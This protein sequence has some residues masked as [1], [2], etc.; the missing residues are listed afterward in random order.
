M[1]LF[2]FLGN[3][4]SNAEIKK[5]SLA[6][7]NDIIDNIYIREL[8]LYI[9][10]SYISNTLSN[11]EIKVYKNNEEIKNELYYKLNYSPNNNQNSNQFMTKIIKNL[12]TKGDCIVIPYNNN[13]FACDGYSKE[14]N[15][16]RDDIFSN[17]SIGNHF[18]NKKM[19]A[20]DVLY[21]KMGDVNA[22]L[23]IDG[24][25]D[26]YNRLIAYSIQDY[27]NNTRIKYK[28][29]L[30]NYGG[31]DREFQEKLNDMLQNDIK[32]YIQS[33]IGILPIYKGTNLTKLDDNKSNSGSEISNILALR[34]EAF[35][36]VA[37]TYKIPIEL[38]LNTKTENINELMKLYISMCIQPIA[39]MIST[40]ITRKTNTYLS[41]KQGNYVKIDTSNITYMNML[42]VSTAI[43]KLIASG[44]CNIDEMRKRLGLNELNTDFS[45]QYYMTK[46]YSTIENLD[47]I[48][49]YSKE[50]I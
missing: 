44:V 25:S 13:F 7:T 28:F 47:N 17:F 24:L 6:I 45:T 34:K 19:P 4:I 1:T 50:V 12:L 43:D 10:T 32:K 31:G 48:D 22:R 42:E 26:Q 37:Q 49:N 23:L 20:S 21:F 2:N 11:C 8:A 46:N 30:E 41:W 14:E 3:K 38:L 35:E 5:K 33:D 16:F 18:L 39:N 9:A 29:E 40:E 36:I 27:I 15:V